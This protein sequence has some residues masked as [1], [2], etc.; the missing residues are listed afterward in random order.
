VSDE[1]CIH[2]KRLDHSW[3]SDEQRSCSEV[4]EAIHD[5]V[6]DAVDKLEGFSRR[7]L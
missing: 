1:S 7:S 5:R 6:L 4:Q 2:K 3:P